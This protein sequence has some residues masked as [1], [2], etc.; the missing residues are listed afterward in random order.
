V[1]FIDSIFLRTRKDRII[2]IIAANLFFFW[3]YLVFRNQ[4]EIPAILTGFT[5]GVFLASSLALLANIYSKIS[6]HA[7]GVGGLLGLLLVILKT[8]PYIPI[9]LALMLVVFIA[10][11]VCTSRMIAGHHTPGEIYSGLL[12]GVLCQY[13][14]ICFIF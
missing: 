4:N 12:V 1:G 8:N 11:V 10:G 5:F 7:I 9:T 14:A 2:P 6:L 3:M 13:I